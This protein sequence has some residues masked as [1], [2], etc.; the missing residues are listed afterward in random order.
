LNSTG[1]RKELSA[2]NFLLMA[3]EAHQSL[4][5]RTFVLLCGAQFLG[6]AQHAMLAPVLPLYVTQLGGS[7][8]VVGMVLASFAATSVIIR[9]L[10]GHWADRWSEAGVMI[11]GLVFQAASILI[12]F[13]PFVSAAMLANG[14]RGI[15]WGGLNTGGYSLLAHIAP[16]ARRG[17]ASGVYSGAQS[18]A[19]ILFPAFALWLLH[20]SFGGFAAV[21]IA[22]TVFSCCGAALGAMMTQRIPKFARDRTASDPARRWWREVF[23]FIEPDILLP[24]VMLAWLNISL[25][26]ITNFSVLYARELGIIEFGPFFIVIGMTSLLGRPLLG[27]LSDRIS[28][29]LS[30]SVGFALQC[31]GL[32]L[33]T[34]VSSLAGMIVCG[35]LYML[36]NAIGS[37]TTLALAVERANPQRR[38]KQMATFSVAYPLSYGVGSVIIGSAVQAAGYAGMFYIMAAVQI[39]GLIFAALKSAD[40]R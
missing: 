11:S 18:S 30:V 37:S 2:K 39:L 32:V 24:S 40:L 27:R 31:A 10:V 7:P 35:T 20:A 29:D 12:C 6:Y 21:F 16:E 19:T 8:F 3:G 5:T 26:A 15:G 22:S 36:G 9:P 25:P 33:I 38:G 1:S 28:R 17:E 34:R 14:L 4:W 23:H 13:I